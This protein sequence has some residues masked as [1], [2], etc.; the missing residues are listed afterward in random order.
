MVVRNAE[1]QGY[2]FIE[3]ARTAL[4]VCDELLISDGYSTDRTWEGLR[5]LRDAFPGRVQLF[6]DRW[7]GEH[8]RG[9]IIAQATNRLRR[10][11]RGEY[12]FSV[13][14]SEI[15]SEVVAKE[16]RG[17][18]ARYPGVEV[19]ALY[20]V[21]LL[22]PHMVWTEGWRYRLF[23]NIPDIV[24][25]G[26]AEDFANAIPRRCPAARCVLSE[27]LYHY[28][29]VCPANYLVKLRMVSPR[30]EAWEDELRLAEEAARETD[31]APVEAFWERVSALMATAHETTDEAPTI[32][33]PVFRKWRYSLDDSLSELESASAVP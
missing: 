33:R 30:T 10:R 13:Q 28:R 3:A 15:V 27:P 31:G 6:R 22:G 9:G 11:C 16:V 18:P 25:V 1:C 19:F 24:A 20:Y 29:A 17:L 32:M 14:A 26:G 12:C 23:R 21:L 8:N 4:A 5:A 7:P 2:P